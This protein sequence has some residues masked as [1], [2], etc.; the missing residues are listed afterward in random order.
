MDKVYLNN[1]DIIYLDCTRLDGSSELVSRYM[2]YKE[3]YVE[4]QI[5][6][7]SIKLNS[8]NQKDKKFY[9]VDFDIYSNKSS[10]SEKTAILVILMKEKPPDECP[11]AILQTLFTLKPFL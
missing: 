5:K 4:E 9:G 3:N 10:F 1:K 8:I 6:S 7:I 2:P 11:R